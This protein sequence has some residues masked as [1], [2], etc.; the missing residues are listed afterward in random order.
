MILARLYSVDDVPILLTDERWERILDGHLE[1]SQSDMDIVL[2]SVEGPEYI[3]RGYGGTLVA[4]VALE[5]SGAKATIRFI[6][7][8][9]MI[10]LQ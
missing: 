4:V 3:L 9:D 8:Q 7:S 10:R 2:N 6:N 1:L 5:K